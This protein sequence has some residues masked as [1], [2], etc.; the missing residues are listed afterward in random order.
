MGLFGNGQQQNL[1]NKYSAAPNPLKLLETRLGRNENPE[2]R[3]SGSFQSDLKKGYVSKLET[4]EITYPNK[5]ESVGRIFNDAS[6]LRGNLLNDVLLIKTDIKRCV[7]G[8]ICRCREKPVAL[9]AHS[10][11]IFLQVA[12]EVSDKNYL[13]FLWRKDDGYIQTLQYNRHFLKAK[14][15]PTLPN[16]AL[17][18]CAK[19][20]KYEFPETSR[21]FW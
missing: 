1:Q 3:Y 21:L 16:F 8:I 14:S 15:S 7:S 12:V 17:Q 4:L 18:Q 10:E 5:P 2:V 6:K 13:P 19:N 9:T 11:E 20:F